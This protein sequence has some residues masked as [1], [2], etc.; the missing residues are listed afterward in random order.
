MRVSQSVSPDRGIRG[1]SNNR[2]VKPVKKPRGRTTK[3]IRGVM[4]RFVKGDIR[5]KQL[6]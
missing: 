4:I 5:G 3:H 2:A 1:I 6:K